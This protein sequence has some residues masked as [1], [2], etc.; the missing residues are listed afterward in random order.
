MTLLLDIGE[1][2]EQQSDR[3]L[4]T[5]YKAI[6]SHD[7]DESIWSEHENPYVRRLVE[8]FTKRGL[9]RLEGFRRDLAKWLSGERHRV[10]AR[11]PRPP[12]AW[13][14]WESD[15]L[16]AVKLYLETLPPAEFTLD[17]WMMVVDYLAQRYLPA[18]DLRTEAEWLAVRSTFMGRVQA[19]MEALTVKQADK[20][21]EAL[22]ATVG[23][24][25]AEFKMSPAQSHVLDYARVR[26]VDNVQ[27]L[28]DNARHRMRQVVLNHTEQ[29][30]LGASAPEHAL[31]ET[32][33]DEFATLN[34]DWRRIAVT[35]AGENLNQGYV[36]SMPIGSKLQRVEQYRNAC[37][38]CRKI[39][40]VVAEV[41]S[42]DD[43]NKDGN[44]QIWPGKNNVGRSSAPRK[45]VG[46]ILVHREP[47]EMW[48]LPAGLAH[49]HCRGRWVPVI[50]DEPGDDKQF[51]DYLRRVLGN[52]DAAD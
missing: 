5:I 1:L 3:A 36:S 40:G 34:R 4:N 15:E 20:V 46:G 30:F 25:R 42:S 13:R 26:G 17:D 50:Q 24:A 41:V 19:N 35:E 11:A 45:R 49:P 16:G 14:R 29:Q 51:G 48:W 21:L 12:D 43:P 27:R 32:L 8:L 28:A 22:P 2:S 31:Q 39:D 18:S 44:T 7:D 52:D 23:A 38:F 9:M 37:S 6:H 47:E 10:G 33:A